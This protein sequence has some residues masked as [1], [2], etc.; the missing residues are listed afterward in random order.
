MFVFVLPEPNFRIS[1]WLW[2]EFQKVCVY[3]YILTLLYINIWENYRIVFHF[4]FCILY[5]YFIICVAT[6]SLLKTY[7]NIFIYS[8]FYVAVFVSIEDILK[9][10]HWFTS[11]MQN[12]WWNNGSCY[13]TYQ[14]FVLYCFIQLQC[15][16]LVS[17]FLC[18]LNSKKYH[19][20]SSFINNEML[21]FNIFWV[22]QSH[23]PSLRIGIYA[24]PNEF[25]DFIII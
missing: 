24:S 22:L 10:F 20:K 21:R 6:I 5:S 9:W 4:C 7:L 3:R 17:C 19:W 18:P 25:N 11:K 8:L 23:L 13:L 2:F 14:K 12:K 1:F 16:S 15:S